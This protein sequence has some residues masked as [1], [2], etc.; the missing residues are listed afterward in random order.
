MLAVDASLEE[1]AQQLEGLETHAWGSV[2]DV[3]EKLV[4]QWE[5]LPAEYISLIVHYAQQPKESVI[6]NLEVF[7]SEVNPALDAL[8]SYAE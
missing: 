8:T 5:L 4:R 1:F 6:R 7:M 3:R 2:E